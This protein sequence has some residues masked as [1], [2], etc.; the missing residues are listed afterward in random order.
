VLPIQCDHLYLSFLASTNISISHF[1]CSYLGLPLHFKKPTR[2]MLQPVIEKIGKRLL[3][4]KQIFFSYPSR[5][6]LVNSVL[7]VM[8]TYFLTVHKMPKWGFAKID[9]Y[10]SF[11]WKG[12]N[13]GKVKGGHCLVNWKT[14]ISPKSL[15]GL[16]IKNLVK[17]SKAL[18]LRWLWHQWDPTEKPWKS[19][20][21]VF[22]PIDSQLFF[23]STTIQVGNGKASPSRN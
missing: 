11:L 1:P 17:F 16:G 14:C 13:L 18:R 20:L 23:N 9:M 3:G 6:L 4:W 15:G 10:R 8:P 5:K 22:D 21:K 2:S 19:L 12:E 7:S